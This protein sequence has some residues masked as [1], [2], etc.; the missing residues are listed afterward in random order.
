MKT[1]KKNDNYLIFL[2]YNKRQ[3]LL[4]IF[5]YILDWE[6]KSKGSSSQ[7][8]HVMACGAEGELGDHNQ[9]SNVALAAKY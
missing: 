5:P 3:G 1:T 8:I 2:N 9:A 7:L 6:T 4:L